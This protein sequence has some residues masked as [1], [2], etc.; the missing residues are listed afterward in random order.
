M[1]IIKQGRTDIPVRHPGK[2]ISHITTISFD[3]DNTLWDFEKVM[4][5]SLRCALDE[6]RRLIPDRATAELTI[7]KMIEIRNDVAEELRGKT[8]NLEE[9][10]LNAFKRTVAHI[11]CEDDK[12][13]TRLNILYLKHRFED[14]ELFPDVF[15][16][17]DILSPHFMIGLLSNGNSYPEKCGLRDRFRFIL[18]SQDHGLEKPD[19]RFFDLAVKT[20]GCSHNQLLH[21]G[22]SLGNDVAGANGAGI[23]S[24]WLNRE[25]EI[26]KTEVIPDFEVS[27]LNE[28]PELLGL[29]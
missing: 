10:R 12:L 18:F 9:I 3:G 5:H 22:D 8:S 21:V 11:G 15:P 29:N 6:L 17:L 7:D 13:A 23:L 14:I 4:R 25:M 16:A 27:S 28:L 26:N 1:E 2:D 24:V 19:G 20:A